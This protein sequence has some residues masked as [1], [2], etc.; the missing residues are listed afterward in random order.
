VILDVYC[1]CP[2]ACAV[3][4][5]RARCFLWDADISKDAGADTPTAYLLNR[6]AGPP[7][8]RVTV[9][10]SPSGGVLGLTGR[11]LSACYDR[12]GRVLASGTAAGVLVLAQET[13]G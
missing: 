9:L 7:D 3:C 6:H 5:R 13:A 8:D 10:L 4:D 11:V 12:M 2:E 1:A